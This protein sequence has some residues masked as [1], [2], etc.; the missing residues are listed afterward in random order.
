MKFRPFAERVNNTTIHYQYFTTDSRTYQMYSNV[1]CT[2]QTLLQNVLYCKIIT[3][4]KGT[5]THYSIIVEYRIPSELTRYYR[6]IV[7][8]TY[9]LS[10]LK[11]FLTTVLTGHNIP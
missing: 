7:H 2:E 5:F 9:P 3:Y 1:N 10:N 4:S 8:T 6:Y 11:A